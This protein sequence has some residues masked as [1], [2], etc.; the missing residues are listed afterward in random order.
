MDFGFIRVGTA[1]P[2]VTVGNCKKNTDEI[3]S[4][5][6]EGTEK[7]LSILV[8]PELCL[9]GYTCGD[10]FLNST[11]LESASKELLRVAGATCNTG[12]A[13]IVGIPLAVNNSLYNTAAV[14]FDGRILAFIPKT[15]VPNYS[16]FYEARHFSPG[17]ET[18][19]YIE[20]PEGN[21]TSKIPF[22][23]NII[24][25]DSS[26]EQ[27]ALFAVEIC[28]DM[29]IPS[30]P[31]VKHSLAGALIIAN[32]S[33]S[34]E[35]I[36]KSEYRKTLVKA[37]SGRLAAAYVY[38]D[39]GPGESTTDM[40]FGGHNLIA[41][42]GAILKESELFNGGLI[43]TE[44]DLQ[45]LNSERRRINTYSQSSRNFD[46]SSYL[47]VPVTLK[48]QDYGKKPTGNGKLTRKIPPLPF[49]PEEPEGLNSRCRDVINY[50][51]QGLI[52]RLEHTRA[53]TAV[54]GLSGGLDSTLALIITSESFKKLRLPETGIQGIT[55]PCFGTTDRTLNN[56]KKLADSLGITLREIPIKKAVMQHF[57]DISHNPEEKNVTYENSQARE[58]TQILM[59]I[60]NEISG[61]VIGTGDMSELALGW[62]TYNGDH[63]SMYGVNASIPKTLVRHL[64]KYYKDLQSGE[65]KEVL[66]DILDTPVSP[67]L[68][69]PEQ[70]KISQKTESIIGPYEL[71][72][73]FLYYTIRW[74]FRPGKI[75]F[76][77]CEAFQ[78]KFKETEILFWLKTFYRRFFSQ[79]YKRSCIPDGPKVGS[80]SLSPRGDW[81]MPSDADG[82][83]WQ[84]E[85]EEL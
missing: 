38:A 59:D 24:F 21:Q 79:Q 16:E 46:L 70:G 4:F 66:T 10:L 45:K 36:G 63:M 84:E 73:F 44:I 60:A 34:N 20:F 67:E 13:V 29:W 78:E 62:A 57:E 48:K 49:I 58:R 64:V 17:F 42:N 41:E 26:F 19:C 76:L 52:K 71:H 7:G 3:I 22:G 27:P 18:P 80:V 74:G 25:K 85:L 35:I 43:Y 6:K 14:I 82:S 33:A 68:L 32:L 77:A 75:F 81:R 31:S 28:E 1:T 69:P 11:L 53:K 37:L 55:M 47:F 56:A 12:M 51:T 30:P 39:A 9:T 5:I 40:V 23:T 72:D 8:F 50:Q 54:L 65:L 83:L 2:R 61:L 15:A